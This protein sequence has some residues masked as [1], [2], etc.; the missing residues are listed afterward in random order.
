VGTGPAAAG[1]GAVA[2]DTVIA[3]G[4]VVDLPAAPVRFAPV[5]GASIVIIALGIYEADAPVNLFRAV[6]T[7]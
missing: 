2:E 7:G 1:I 6:Q 4:A 3:A 5:I